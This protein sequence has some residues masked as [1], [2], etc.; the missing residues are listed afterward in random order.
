[1]PCPRWRYLCRRSSN[2]DC[3]SYH[4]SITAPRRIVATSSGSTR[5]L[6]Q[7]SRIAILCRRPRFPA[8]SIGNQS[9]TIKG[10]SRKLS[11]DFLINPA[12]ASG[13]AQIDADSRKTRGF[14]QNGGRGHAA[15]QRYGGKIAGLVQDAAKSRNWDLHGTRCTLRYSAAASVLVMARPLPWRVTSP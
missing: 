2:V 11:A 14:P 7:C 1:M 4:G 6:S 10:L 13:L 15:E 5:R 3:P 12:R 8:V 9:A